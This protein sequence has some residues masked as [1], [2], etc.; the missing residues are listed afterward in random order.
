MK[1]IIDNIK[2]NFYLQGQGLNSFESKEESEACDESVIVET[3]F[4][5]QLKDI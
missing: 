2:N 1:F 4:V 3:K 5:K